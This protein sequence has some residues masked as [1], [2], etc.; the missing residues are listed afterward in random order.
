VIFPDAIC[1]ILLEVSRDSIII[2]QSIVDIEQE[3]DHFGH[4]K[5]CLPCAM[6][7]L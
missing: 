3:Y 2:E 6:N 7:Q 5:A 1:Q 4:H